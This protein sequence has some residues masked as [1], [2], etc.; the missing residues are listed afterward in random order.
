MKAVVFCIQIF[1][2]LNPGLRLSDFRKRQ[3]DIPSSL[4][5]DMAIDG[6]NFDEKD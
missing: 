5:H 3:P 1:V 6:E 4:F 2:L